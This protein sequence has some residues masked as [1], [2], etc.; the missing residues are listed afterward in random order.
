MRYRLIA[1]SLS[2][3]VLLTACEHSQITPIQASEQMS[4]DPSPHFALTPEQRARLVP[5]INVDSLERFL[6]LAASDVEERNTLAQLFMQA[7]GTNKAFHIVGPAVSDPKLK[8]LLDEIYA[9]TWEAWGAE[10]IANSDSRLPGRELARAKLMA[11]S[12]QSSKD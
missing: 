11:R 7:A 12:L 10:A 6:Q 3:L 2:L 1:G 8:A 4:A 5:N 9:P